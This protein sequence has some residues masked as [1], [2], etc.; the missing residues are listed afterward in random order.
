MEDDVTKQIRV[1]LADD[2]VVV[3]QGIRRFL[4]EDPAIEVVAEA[5]DGAEVVHLVEEHR[6]DVAVLDIRMP[7]VTG[8]EA[9][10]RIKHRF[11]NTRVLILTAYDDDPYVFALLEAGAD[12]YVLKTAGADELI[13]AVRT[14]YRGESALS[15][16]VA[17]KVVQQATGRRPASAAD[18]IEPLTPRE[19]DVLRLVADGMTN[20]EVGRE[21]GISHRTVQGHLAS[22]Y[23]KLGANSRTEAVTE[24]LKRGWI[25]IE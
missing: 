16:E 12:G 2:H 25:V 17:S 11:P 15:P 6:P 23:G 8:V 9:T 22:I 5:S 4:E 24:A 3:R 10:R 20:R 13:D 19:I 18:Q 21:L 14:V 1:I 7:E